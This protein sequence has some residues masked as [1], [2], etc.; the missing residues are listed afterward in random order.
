[1]SVQNNQGQF[2]KKD[3]PI[4]AI[5]ASA[6]G[7]Q[8]VTELLENL[9]ADTG[10]GYIYI[11]HLDRDHPSKLTE[12]LSRTTKMEVLEATHLLNIEANKVYII[13]PD[14]DM[15]FVDG[16]LALN[17]RQE[18]PTL[19]M[20]VDRFFVSLA[21]N[22]KTAIGIILSGAASDGTLGLKAIKTEGGLTFAQDETAQFQS[23]P[24][25]A[26]A[27]GVADMVLSPKAIAQEL[28][29]L[30]KKAIPL[31]SGASNAETAIS[32]TDEDLASI[33]QLLRK[34]T[35]V[36]FRHYKMNT[37]KRRIIRRILLY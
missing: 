27:D 13:P 36:D 14:K 26:I 20:P 22:Y 9:P 24:R 32:D 31:L 5:G 33:I 11:Q 28:E 16:T 4:V 30:A 12:I 7:L 29:R 23:M 6:G 19:H 15:T 17:R 1:M 25:S 21:E 37:I 18:K 10:M 3:F 2:T 35:G 34:S 8:A